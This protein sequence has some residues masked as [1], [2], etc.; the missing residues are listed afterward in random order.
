MG[1]VVPA[2]EVELRDLGRIEDRAQGLA[3]RGG[4]GPG[5][6]AGN[7]IRVVGGV[8]AEVRL[9]DLPVPGPRQA[10]GVD[11]GGVGLERHLLAQAIEEDGGNARTL[12]A[13]GRLELHER[14]QGDD[15]PQARSEEHTSE[16][17]SPDHLVCRLLLEKKKKA[18]STTYSRSS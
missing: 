15:L 6:E 18:Q 9:V 16:L 3:S 14:G 4:D 5:R 10:Q 8:D 13:L 2:H 17:Q 7:A 1:A 12:L 11:D